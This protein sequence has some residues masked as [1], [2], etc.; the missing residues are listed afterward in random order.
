M[1]NILPRFQAVK[2]SSTSHSPLLTTFKS[3]L[4]TNFC[5]KGRSDIYIIQRSYEIKNKHVLYDQNY[6]LSHRVNTC[7]MCKLTAC[8]FSKQLKYRQM[9]HK[10]PMKSIQVFATRIQILNTITVASTFICRNAKLTFLCMLSTFKISKP[11]TE[12][13]SSPSKHPPPSPPNA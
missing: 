7:S 6:S 2:I 11:Q 3:S 12:V 8:L 4:K 9:A 10:Q 1:D 5:V 13:F